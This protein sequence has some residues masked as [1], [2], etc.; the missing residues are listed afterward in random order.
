MKQGA[1]VQLDAVG[2]R[3]AVLSDLDE[4]AAEARSL[5]MKRVHLVAWRD[6]ADPEA[7]GS[8]LH[9]HRIASLWASAGLD[10]TMRT[11][12]A[13]GHPELE[14]RERYDVVRRSG[15][16]A[17]FPAS[18]VSGWRNIGP[19]DGLVEIWNGM[20]F[21]SPLWARGP[22]I[23][24]L[25]HVHAEMWDMVLPPNLAKLG[26]FV[27]QRLAPPLYRNTRIVTL[28]ESSRSEIVSMLRMDPR[29]VSVVAPGVEARFGPGGV[30]SETPLVVAVGRLVPVKRFGALMDALA[31]V[32]V[33]HPELRAVIVGEGY[34]RERLEARRNELGAESWIEMP[35]KLTDGQLVEI[36]R[37]AWVLASASQREGWGMTITEAG[38][39]G[40]PAVAT[41]IA[42]HADAI[43]DGRTGILVEDP[44]TMAGA[45]SRLVSGAALRRRL[46]DGAVAKSSGYTWEQ[47]AA[48]TLKAL[49]ADARDRRRRSLSRA[50][51]GAARGLLRG[52]GRSF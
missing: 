22:R 42:G 17:V 52:S 47:T 37:S 20:P 33:D 21:F 15:R 46:S 38:A 23:V 28:S 39:C 50:I 3:A 51:H 29:R 2:P 34:E 1:A 5:G 48:G 30:R 32:K 31:K 24:F 18:A 13:L 4:V 7:G 14:T 27:E 12:R 49:V 35:G 8:E 25:H 11:S 44:A 40:T 16:Y 10:V 26:R 43:D 19:S 45:V 36:Y 6:L 9:A 41:R